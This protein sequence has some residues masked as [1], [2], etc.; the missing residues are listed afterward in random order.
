[1]RFHWTHKHAG[2]LTLILFALLL[3]EMVLS[4]GLGRFR[5]HTTEILR[6]LLHT[7]LWHAG[8]TFYDVPW[9]VVEIIRLPR[10]LMVT[11][12]GVGLALA[13]ATMQ[14]VFRNPL[15]GPDVVGVSQGASLGGVLAILLGWQPM[16]IVAMAFGFGLVGLLL[17]FVLARLAGR[18]STLALVL[19]GIIIGSFF[20]SFLGLAQYYADPQTQLPGITYWLLG[21]FASATYQKV[22]IVAAATLLAGCGLLL[23]RWRINLFSLNETDAAM[24]GT[25]LERLRWIVIA[26]VVLLVASQVSVSGGVGWVGLIIPHLARMLV[27]PEH[28]KLLPASG[29]LGGIYLLTMDDL[30]RSMASQEIPIGL[31]TGIVGAPVF[32]ILF[33][34]TQSKGWIHD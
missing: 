5:L 11:L 21:S 2:L 13:G 34:K 26:F 14:G 16:G 31:L 17:A 23:L 28:S 25:N 33:W 9:V 7:R 20:S 22:T 18:T 30:A 15:V 1:M 8:G 6:V 3:A 12:C 4:L 29:F 10:I 24:L 27:G 19:S 32:A